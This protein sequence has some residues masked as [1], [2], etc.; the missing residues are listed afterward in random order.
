M[1]LDRNGRKDYTAHIACARSPVCAHAC[2]C[3]RS[4][5][6][7]LAEV[8]VRSL[9]LEIALALACEFF[10]HE[11]LTV[12]CTHTVSVPTRALYTHV[13]ASCVSAHA[14]A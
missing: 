12:P 8:A 10:Q 3:V 5:T 2:V 4:G 9:K 13:C 1:P 14:Y 7:P 11:Q 6:D